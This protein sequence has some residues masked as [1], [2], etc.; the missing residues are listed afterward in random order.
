MI[1]DGCV[2]EKI[3]SV[4]QVILPVLAMLLVGI[5]ARRKRLVSDTGI[6]DMKSLLSNVCIPAT[7]FRTFY[8]DAFSGAA[9]VLSLSMAVFVAAAWLL[10]YAAQ[11][12]LRIEQPMAPYFCTSIEGGMMGYALFILLFGQENLYYLALLDLGNA[13]I[14]FPIMLTKL[15]LRTEPSASFRESLKGLITPINLA[16]VSG[17]AINLTGF[18]NVLTASG[19]NEVLDAL[20]SFLS[21]PVSALILLIVGYGL[22]F[23]HVRWGET[24]KTIAARG[25]IFA[26]FGSIIYR[27][28]GV[29][30][31]GDPMGG[32]GVMMAFILPP[33]FMFSVFAESDAEESYVGSVLAIYTLF[34]LAAYG[35]LAWMV[36]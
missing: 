5:L 29:C 25:V 21:A 16:I 1:G 10:G 8:T 31:P 36:V 13:L 33:T 18:G 24:F 17:L 9:A 34:S 30:M 2:V 19:V 4:L 14:V 23:S 12:L 11:K 22:D 3:F 6:A 26:V 35:V 28:V 32:Y 15:R 27:L 20:L 7:I